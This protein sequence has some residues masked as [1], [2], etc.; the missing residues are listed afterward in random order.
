MATQY[1]AAI[2]GVNY[3]DQPEAV[4]TATAAATN[5]PVEDV[6]NPAIGLAWRITGLSLSGGSATFTV[7][8]ERPRDFTLAMLAFVVP[9]RVDDARNIDYPMQI[10][11]TDTVRWQLSDDAN[12]P[13]NLYDVTVPS[14]LQ[15]D[16]GVHAHGPVEIATAVL[17]LDM[18][19]SIASLPASPGDVADIGR[20]WAGPIFHFSVNHEW[21]A[22][23][24][25]F[26]DE[27]R[28]RVREWRP[29]FPVIRDTERVL[30]ER[31]QQLTVDEH[32]VIYFPRL[33][34]PETGFIGRFRDP[35]SF[36]RG[37]FDASQWGI[38]LQED[39]LGF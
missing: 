24:R 35:G 12:T 19:I 38:A 26:R 32:Q 23:F 6:T 27:L 22:P 18:T 28:H 8:F 5:M 10:A 36:V 7:V 21:G 39:W 31:I 4:L 25:W 16:L 9:E 15:P 17:R 29:S 3:I 33:D 20:I 34:Q 1:R 13:G 14:N 11:L 30:L 2:G 37:R